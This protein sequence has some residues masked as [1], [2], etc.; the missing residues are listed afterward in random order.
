MSDKKKTVTIVVNG[1]AHEWPKGEITYEEVVTLEVPDYPQHPEISYSVKY[2]RGHGNRPEGTLSPG[3]SVRVKEG[4][5]F[6]VSETGQ[7]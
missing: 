1:T 5:S 7:S 3:G 6:S 4:M 2:K